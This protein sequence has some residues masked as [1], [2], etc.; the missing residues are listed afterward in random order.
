MNEQ[1]SP[2]FD[3][4][5]CD[6][7]IDGELSPGEYREFL[8]GLDAVPDGWRCLALA[9][10]E[11]QALGVEIG[12]VRQELDCPAKIVV[13]PQRAN[14]WPAAWTIALAIAGCM[15]LAVGL[16]YSL[17]GWLAADRPGTN[18]LAQVHEADVPQGEG[19]SKPVAPR[20][21]EKSDGPLGNLTLVVNDGN[22]QGEEIRVPVFDASDA[23]ERLTFEPSGIPADVRQTLERTGHRVEELRQL[24]PVSLQDGRQIVLPVEQYRIVPVARRSY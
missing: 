6:R 3:E 4:L 17:R 14:L 13:Q 2:S 19:K 9:F 23:A 16:G 15:L 12:R 1:F 5:A 24:V 18:N 11:A 7:L 21:K 10:L 8:V 20:I 22:A